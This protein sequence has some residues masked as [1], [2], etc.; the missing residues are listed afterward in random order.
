M[1]IIADN[2]MVNVKAL[3]E[4]L[5]DIINIIDDENNLKVK[6]CNTLKSYIKNRIMNYSELKQVTANNQMLIFN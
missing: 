6:E 3:T 5:D 1:N 4:E 2:R